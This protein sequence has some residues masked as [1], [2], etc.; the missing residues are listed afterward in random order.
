MEFSIFFHPDY[1]VGAGM[2]RTR[3]LVR[4]AGLCA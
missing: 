1:T 2:N 3:P 4:L